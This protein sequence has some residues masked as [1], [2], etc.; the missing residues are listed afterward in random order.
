MQIKICSKCE[1]DLP[2]TTEYFY[3]NKTTKD[4]LSYYCKVCQ[5]LST[6]KWQKTHSE[7]MKIIHKR[8]LKTNNGKLALQRRSKK[9]RY[10]TIKGYIKKLFYD[11]KRRCE[12]PSRHNYP[13]YG[14]RGIKLC[15]SVDA[16]YDFVCRENIDPR[17]LELH[18]IDNDGHYALNNI[19]FLS[20]E[21]HKQEHCKN[22]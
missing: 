17:N 14:G 19:E 5:N 20:N 16:L 3:K 21:E 2:A 6:R 12:N 22:F 4:K 11:I 7:N 1:K 9:A 13:Y 10:G 18:R 8:Y 15:F